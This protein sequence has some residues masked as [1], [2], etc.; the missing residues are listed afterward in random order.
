MH[1]GN[2]MLHVSP[3]I[4]GLVIDVTFNKGL[5]VAQRP[6]KLKSPTNYKTKQ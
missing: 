4:N 5:L 6:S 1:P 3:V 2:P